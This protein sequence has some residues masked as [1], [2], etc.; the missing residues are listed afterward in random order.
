VSMAN[1]GDGRDLYTILECFADQGRA[2]GL[3]T[4]TQISHATPACFAAHQP[5]RYLFEPAIV[6]D[7]LEESRPNVLF[8]GALHMTPELAEEAGYEVV[9]TRAELESLSPNT[10][11]A[12]GQFAPNHMPYEYDAAQAEENPYEVIPHL[13]EMVS[14]ALSRLDR[15][16][17]GFFLLVEGGRIDHGGHDNSIERNVLETVAFDEAVEAVLTWAEGRDDTLIVVTADHETGGLDVVECNSAGAW[18]SVTWSS[19]EHTGVPVN[20]YAWGKNADRFGGTIDNTD[21]FTAITSG[22]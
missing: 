10:E 5:V 9:T 8:G 16:P 12:S 14:A 7:Y 19:D 2:T 15:N 22:P 11:F 17:A 20:T 3:V 18:P 4:T 1:P 6:V 21:F 13:Q